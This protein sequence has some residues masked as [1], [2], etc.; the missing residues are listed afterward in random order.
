LIATV[1]GYVGE[2][3]MSDEVGDRLCIASC[4]CNLISLQEIDAYFEFVGKTSAFGLVHVEAIEAL[5]VAKFKVADFE[6]W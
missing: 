6:I 3:S 5:N 4:F 1:H 2:I